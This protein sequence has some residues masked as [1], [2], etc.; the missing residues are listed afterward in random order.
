MFNIHHIYSL[1]IYSHIR[2]YIYFN[3]HA[4]I[5]TYIHILYTPKYFRA[6]CPFTI[7]EGCYDM[8]S[9]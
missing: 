9:I 4:Y 8:F 3:I 2:V 6:H 7:R 1:S 5:H